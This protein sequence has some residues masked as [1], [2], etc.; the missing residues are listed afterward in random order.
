MTRPSL[1]YFVTQRFLKSFTE[2]RRMFGRG[3]KIT[4]VATGFAKGNV[5]VEAAHS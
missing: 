4:I 1:I 2:V 5:D 3:H